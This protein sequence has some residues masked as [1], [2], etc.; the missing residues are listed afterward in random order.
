MLQV[1]ADVSSSARGQQ[2]VVISGDFLFEDHGRVL[3]YVY[4][5][6]S[7]SAGD[8]SGL[9]SMSPAETIPLA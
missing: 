4:I 8:V 9:Q 5:L 2:L 3:L 1:T 7:S 6:S